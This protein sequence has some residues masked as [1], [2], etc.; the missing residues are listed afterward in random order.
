M[1][2]FRSMDLYKGII[3][4]SLLLAPV[5]A[6]WVMSLRAS[7]DETQKSIT[8]ATRPGGLLDEIGSLERGMDVVKDNRTI[9]DSVSNPAIYFQG[10][11]LAS[12]GGHIS[13]SD[14]TVPPPQKKP[15]S[16]DKQRFIDYEQSVLFERKENGRNEMKLPRDF[17]WA[18]ILNC[19]FGLGGASSASAAANSVWKLRELDMTN[20]ASEDLRGNKTPPPE[21]TDDW[22]LKKLVFAR[23]APDTEH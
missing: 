13:Q 7:I 22:L 6:W 20:A 11:I 9:A 19:E 17:I 2:L 18:V 23:R 4:L 16:V 1:N 3:V 8:A 14:F 10:Q 12:A 21:L 5:G 15:G